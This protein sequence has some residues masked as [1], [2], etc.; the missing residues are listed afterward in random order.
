MLRRC[1]L[2]ASPTA[3]LLAALAMCLTVGGCGS[4]EPPSG[5]TGGSPGF[6]LFMLF[7]IIFSHSIIVSRELLNGH[8]VRQLLLRIM[9][10]GKYKENSDD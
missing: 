5:G 9:S 3:P 8:T 6:F 2:L 1:A 10:P 7:Q 4:G